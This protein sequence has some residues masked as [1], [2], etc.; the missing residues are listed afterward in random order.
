MPEHELSY[1]ERIAVDSDLT[2]YCIRCDRKVEFDPSN[3]VESERPIGARFRCT[4]CHEYGL[5]IVSPKWRYNSFD[6]KIPYATAASLPADFYG[7]GNFIGPRP[8][9]KRKRRRR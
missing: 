7:N 4:I 5:C 6:Q 9:P 3:I 8:E 1:G 2:V